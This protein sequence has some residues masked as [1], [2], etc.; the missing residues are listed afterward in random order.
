MRCKEGREAIGNRSEIW[1]AIVKVLDA[2]LIS[3]IRQPFQMS[4]KMTCRK[5]GNNRATI[6]RFWRP[7][8]RGHDSIFF[9]AT[10]YVAV[11]M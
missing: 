6:C 10:L 7:A 11:I 8:L 3:R 4:E 2:D 1:D 5:P 9:P